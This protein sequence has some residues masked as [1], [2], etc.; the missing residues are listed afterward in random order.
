MVAELLQQVRLIDPVTNT[1]QIVDVL[2]GEG[3]IW[4]IAEQISDFPSDAV[5]RG[6]HGQVLGPGLV[7]LYS[8]SGSPGHEERETLASLA[9]AAA[10]GGFTRIGILPD[11]CP[12]LDNPASIAWIIEQW[13]TLVGH[14]KQEKLPRL[15]P[16]AALTVGAKGQ[17]MAELAELASSQIIGFADGQPL[18]NW[19]LV[20]RLL[21]YSQ[22]LNQPI[23]LWPC[24]ANLAEH[25]TMREGLQSIQLG[26]P[27]MPTIA[28]TAALSALLECV[29]AIGS[30]VHLMRLST[31]RGIELVKTAKAQQIPVT[32][33]TTWMHLLLNS[34]A[35]C[36]YDPNLH[37]NPPL[38]NPS[39][40]QALIEAVIDGTLDAIAI[41]HTPYTYE[42]KTVA[43]AEAPP[44]VIG[45]ELALPLLWQT[46]V[47][48]GQ[49]SAV[50]LWRCL[51][52]GPISCL[53]EQV[54]A[55]SIG[56]ATELTLFNPAAPWQATPEML[57]SD[58]INTPWLGRSILGRVE[59]IWCSNF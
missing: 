29:A 12:A 55:I 56:Q 21:E 27:G 45:Y 7:D 48:T 15:R 54:R 57:K 39:D 30:P 24:D 32:A 14:G 44:G 40:Q 47:E 42:E 9:K 13:Q 43:F 34:E 26:L 37:L 22:T 28:E 6:G 46:L 36:H 5:I 2:L 4:A 18:N 11:T 8:H 3:R 41:D 50:Q 20:R 38:G 1:D 58:A 59:T 51:S 16:W 31:A 17:Q 25:G 19:N 23:A 35:I 52:S 33:S 53:G 49:L 10:A